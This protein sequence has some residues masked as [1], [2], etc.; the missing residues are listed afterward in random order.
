MFS[1]LL[2]RNFECPK[3]HSENEL[4]SSVGITLRGPVNK[5]SIIELVKSYF[6]KKIST[7]M[8][9]Q[10]RHSSLESGWE[11]LKIIDYP[12]YL[13]IFLDPLDDE[14]GSF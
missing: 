4:T 7:R 2:S 10:C 6:A 3:N 9:E 12:R 11:Q 13:I 5:E 14:D 1:F 8:C